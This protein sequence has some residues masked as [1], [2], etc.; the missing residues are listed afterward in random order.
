MRRTLFAAALALAA[1]GLAGQPQLA[2]LA[3]EVAELRQQLAETRRSGGLKIG[4][5]DIVRVF[6]ELDQKIDMDAELRQREGRRETELRELA[7]HI[8]DLT[9]ALKLLR[10]GSAEYKKN[11]QEL[12]E[13]KSEFRSRREATEDQLY[14]KLFDLTLTIYKKIRDEV[15]DVARESGY[16]LV[17][18]VRDPDIA[19]FDRALRPRHKYLE[20]NR[21]IEYHDV[22][23]HKPASDFSDVVI[24]RL[25]EKYQREKDE[26]KKTGPPGPKP[27]P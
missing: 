10:E 26:R 3:R 13:T 23:F 25:N 7:K 21:R 17:L 2:D 22:F 16:D 19:N 1:T 18:R 27:E 6:D 15:R 4:F 11:S 20:L 14:N 12:E 5:V 9:E 24:R 8:R